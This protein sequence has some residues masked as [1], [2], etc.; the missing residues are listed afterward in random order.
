MKYQVRINEESDP[1]IV[2]ALE[3]AGNTSEWLREAA[4]LKLEYDKV[5]ADAKRKRMEQD[6]VMV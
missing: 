4:R 6:V 3:A 1:E 5:M 2:E